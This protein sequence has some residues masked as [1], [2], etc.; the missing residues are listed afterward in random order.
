M[1]YS[2]A[3][4]AM[5]SRRC[6]WS[7]TASHELDPGFTGVANQREQARGDRRVPGG[8]AFGRVGMLGEVER[9]RGGHGVGSMSVR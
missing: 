3:A 8:A 5:M 1:V 9:R 4:S 7:V 2:F 6:W